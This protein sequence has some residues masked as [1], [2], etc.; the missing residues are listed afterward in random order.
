MTELLKKKKKEK[1]KEKK[2]KKRKEKKKKEKKKKIKKKKTDISDGQ[3]KT[4]RTLDACRFQSIYSIDMIFHT[5]IAQSVLSKYRKFCYSNPT[6]FY[7]NVQD[8]P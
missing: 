1:E 6:R 8:V 5:C 2:E 3:K 4:H 7:D